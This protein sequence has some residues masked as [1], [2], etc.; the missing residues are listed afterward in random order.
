M[1]E[2]TDARRERY[3]TGFATMIIHPDKLNEA[4]AAARTINAGR[5]RYEAVSTRTN[6]V[7]WF[8]IGILHMRE[9]DGDFSTYLGDGERLNHPTHCV[10]QGRGP[11]GCFE[12][13][14]V[15]ALGH[16]G[17]QKSTDWTIGSILFHMEQ[18]NGEG[19][20][21][22]GLPSPYVWAGSD[23]YRSGKFGS[24]GHFDKNLVDKQLGGAVMLSAMIQLGF[25]SRPEF[26][27]SIPTV[28]HQE[29]K[30]ADTSTTTSAPAATIAVPAST[31]SAAANVSSTTVVATTG[32]ASLGAIFAFAGPLLASFFPNTS[33]LIAEIAST[34][35]GL[36][37]AAGAVVH[38]LHLSTAAAQLTDAIIANI[39][40]VS[41]TVASDLGGAPAASPA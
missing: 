38:A 3:E 7:P 37:V 14:A 17:F 30:M 16:E 24:D 4:H 9:S 22:R 28:Q 15:D 18:F 39:A 8:L 29:A 32:I 20:F 33:G 19:Y 23:Q 1:T 31:L 2:L 6:G 21:D 41:S 12:D 26:R 10:P 27:T 40:N 5:S 25:I 35:P 13:G 36:A 11:F 34:I